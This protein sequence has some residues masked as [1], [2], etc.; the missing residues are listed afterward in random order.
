MQEFAGFW[1]ETFR[2]DTQVI[3]DW[4]RREGRA[5]TFQGADPEFVRQQVEGLLATARQR[6]RERL[7]RLLAWARDSGRLPG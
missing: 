7:T 3:L 5:L 1:L 4:Y 2:R 6:L